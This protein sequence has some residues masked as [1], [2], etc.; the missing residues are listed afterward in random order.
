MISLE[1]MFKHLMKGMT[2]TVVPSQL[3]RTVQ[4][5][6]AAGARIDWPEN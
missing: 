4:L 3:G 1:E 2:T 6:R 5:L